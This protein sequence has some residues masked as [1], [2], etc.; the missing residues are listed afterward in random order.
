MANKYKPLIYYSV[1]K[2]LIKK[3]SPELIF[4]QLVMADVIY[5]KS[6]EINM[7]LLY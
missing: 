1:R 2:R 7:S 3:L 6:K 4:N 5:N